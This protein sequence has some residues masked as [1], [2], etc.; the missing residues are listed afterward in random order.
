MCVD[1]YTVYFKGFKIYY[2]LYTYG[3]AQPNVVDVIKFYQDILVI[4]NN[5]DV[6]PGFLIDDL[7][8]FAP[9]GNVS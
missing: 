2:P 7:G 1:F 3:V 9:Y 5:T 6:F 8:Y 4:A